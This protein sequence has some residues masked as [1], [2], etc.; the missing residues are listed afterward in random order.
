M[1]IIFRLLLAPFSLLYG[2]VVGFR[3]LLYKKGVLRAVSFDIPVI[4]VG[5][6]SVGG[7][8]KSPHVEYI[9]SY[10]KEY[11]P[12]GTLSRGYK[13][14]T[15]GTRF[16][17]SKNQ[18]EDVGD[19]ALQIKLK[20]PDAVVAV[21]EK[22]VLA[23]PEMLSKYPS[24][25]CI[26][27]DDAFQ[28]LAVN[29]GLSILLTTYSEPFYQDFILPSG[30]LREWRDG[31]ERADLI[32]VSKCPAQLSED[33]KAAM[34][35]KINPLKGQRVFFSYYEYGKPYF[36]FG[37]KYQLEWVEDID[38]ILI[39]GIAN[40]KY[41][42]DYL[43]EN[44]GRLHTMSFPDHHYFEEREI[45]DLIQ[46]FNSLKTK[47]KA[48]ITTEKDAVRLFRYKDRFIQNNIPLFVIPVKVKFHFDQEEDFR[49]Q[50]RSFLLNFTV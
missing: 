10:L 39:C 8:G 17:H 30:R 5:N 22:R 32:I 18:V 21:S 24:L 41:L 42:E 20:Y 15:E 35:S 4:T 38:A 3:R 19:E 23:I 16:V 44:V 11:L 28:H 14:R 6:L 50:L 7:T 31:Y 9:L 49:Q 33:K 47:R 48:V 12:V 27:L 43:I 1:N 25:K 26:I 13:R 46:R 2:V 36:L 45:D 37:P 29:P 34:I 40:P